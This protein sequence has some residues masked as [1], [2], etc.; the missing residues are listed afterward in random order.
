MDRNKYKI[1][2]FGDKIPL[3]AKG[4]DSFSRGEGEAE[5]FSEE[6]RAGGELERGDKLEA[7][8]SSK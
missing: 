5:V 6:S 3:I 1:S 8:T 2:L 4:E 7:S